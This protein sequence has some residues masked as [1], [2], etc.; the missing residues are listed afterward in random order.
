MADVKG[1]I[2]GLAV[3][4]TP[5]DKLLQRI[6]EIGIAGLHGR[7]ESHDFLGSLRQAR[8][9]GARDDQRGRARPCS[10]RVLELN[11]TQEGVL[12][13]VFKLAD[14][15]GWLLLDID[16]LRTLVTHCRRQPQGNLVPIR[17]GQRT[18]HRGDPARAAAAWPSRVATRSSANRRWSS[19]TSCV[20]HPTGRGVISILAA[21]QLILKP[22][23][24]SSFLLWLLSELFETL[25]E[26][27]DLDK[28]EACVRVRRGAPALRR[29]A[30]GPAATN[31]AGRCG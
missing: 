17:T 19:P 23:L 6:A 11:D 26:V 3:A 16:D 28:P 4:G 14:D 25:P 18:I 30:T 21:D 22:R 10:V 12:E 2:A 7:S 27:G 8:P 13:I 9:S 5:N 20:R 15:N 24:Y 31:R 29:R 1:D